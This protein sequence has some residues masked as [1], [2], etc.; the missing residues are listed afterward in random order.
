MTDAAISA[1]GQLR[2]IV[3]RIERVESDIAELNA[4]KSEIYKEA[5]ANGF[6][7][8][9][10]RAL[11][12]ERRKDPQQLDLF[13]ATLDLYRAALAGARAREAA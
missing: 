7:V 12:A 9:A 4:D 10:L 1:D 8:K 5:K 13:D 11:I 3:E 6:D 2:S